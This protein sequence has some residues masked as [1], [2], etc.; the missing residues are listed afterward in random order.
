MADW[1]SVACDIGRYFVE[2]GE[3]RMLR[4][5]HEAVTSGLTFDIG[6]FKESRDHKLV[7]MVWRKE[8]RNPDIPAGHVADDKTAKSIRKF[9]EIPSEKKKKRRRRKKKQQQEQESSSFR[10]DE[11]VVISVT[12]E[13]TDYG[14]VRSPPA[15]S[16]RKGR[17]WFFVN[18][19]RKEKKRSEDFALATS[20]RFTPLQGDYSKVSSS[21]ANLS[22]IFVCPDAE[23][24]AGE[25]GINGAKSLAASFS[26]RRDRPGDGQEDSVR[27][28][29][30][31]SLVD[32]FS[33]DKNS[34][35][36][37]D[38]NCSE[39]EMTVGLNS[40]GHESSLGE[41][42]P[43][44]QPSTLSL[45]PGDKLNC[46]AGASRSEQEVADENLWKMREE[47]WEKFLRENQD[48][49]RDNYHYNLR[50]R[51]A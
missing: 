27:E 50:E 43:P 35:C 18:S 1:M 38:I 12:S 6:D 16:S 8:P 42:S 26:N 23:D 25:V 40:D 22:H 31:P 4:R 29:P 41:T 14:M 21:Q 28:I 36:V 17:S 44:F 11:S 3:E 13:S 33:P 49:L 47:K 19:G 10:H 45:P 32:S 34:L 7:H 24:V 46:V 2:I 39:K 51:W 15:S 9:D 5:L 48:I 37:A 30:P 20:N